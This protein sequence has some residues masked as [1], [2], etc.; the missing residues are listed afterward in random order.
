MWVKEFRGKKDDDPMK[1]EYWLENT[2]RMLD[3]MMCPP[4]DSLKYVKSLLKEVY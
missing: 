1:V 2:L 3:E 4:K